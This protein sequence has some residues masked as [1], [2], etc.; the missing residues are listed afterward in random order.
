MVFELPVF[1]WLAQHPLPLFR[2]KKR[3]A[4]RS[5]I[6]GLLAAWPVGCHASI[7]SPAGDCFWQMRSVSRLRATARW[8]G[9]FEQTSWNLSSPSDL[10]HYPGITASAQPES[11]LRFAV[12]LR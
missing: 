10:A 5:K 1:D 6:Q 4:L 7:R 9:G 8:L 2:R 3:H 11:L 12:V